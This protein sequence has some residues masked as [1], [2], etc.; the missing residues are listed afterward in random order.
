M[1]TELSSVC[2]LPCYL[3]EIS[4]EVDIS[5][6]RTFCLSLCIIAQSGQFCRPLRLSCCKENWKTDGNT[7]RSRFLLLKV[8]FL[9]CTVYKHLFLKLIFSSDHLIDLPLTSHRSC[10]YSRHFA[11]TCERNL[12]RRLDY[13]PDRI[14]IR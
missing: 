3:W 9:S 8:L 1:I 5:S 2:K 13:I 11:H 12:F 7:Q 14:G 10:R 4:S 6:S